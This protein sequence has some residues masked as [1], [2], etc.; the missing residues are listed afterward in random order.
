MTG[1][2]VEVTV[3]EDNNL[4]RIDK[5][6]SGSLEIDFSRSFL[7]KLIRSGHIR[8]GG[9]AI[10]PNYKVKSDD[11]ITIDIP[12]PEKLELLPE[13]IPLQ[14]VYDDAS[15]VVINKQ[16][17][18][19][20]HPGPGHWSRTLVNGLLFHIP[21][22]SSIGGVDRPGIVH[23]LDKDTAGLM[24]VAKD[25]AAHR[26]LTGEFSARRVKKRYSTIVIG[27]P[28]ADHGRIDLPIGRH[29][30]YRHKMAVDEKGRDAVTE[31]TLKRVWNSRLGVF[32]M[33]DINLL[34][35]RTHQIRVH[36]SSIG[37]PIVGDPI[38]SKKWEKYKVPFLLLASTGLEFTHPKE[39]ILLKFSIDLPDHIRAFI[40][41]IERLKTS[42]Q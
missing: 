2:I 1:T 11:L 5:F 10:K 7:Q 6:L 8:A 14:I 16:P 9:R 26:F 23:R 35:G 38:Y 40:E 28:A 25:D 24:V 18:L 29:R 22:L 39:T 3:P 41:R 30:K 34:T 12:E 20:V 27:K 15:L 17:G 33:L 13:D 21:D 19:P 37:L 32:S 42:G 31:F 4:E 36:L